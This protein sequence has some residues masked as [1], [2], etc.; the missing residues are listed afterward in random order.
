MGLLYRKER[1]SASLKDIFPVIW[2]IL[3]TAHIGL[4][5]GMAVTAERP[6]AVVSYNNNYFI[7]TTDPS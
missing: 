4:Q 2:Q 1:F 7:R 6:I 5:S 3:V